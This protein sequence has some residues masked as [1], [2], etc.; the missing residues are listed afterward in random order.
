MS[1]IIKNVNKLKKTPFALSRRS[2]IDSFR[3]LETLRYVNEL[4]AQGENIIRLEAGQ[5]CFGAP[6]P[7][8]KYAQEMIARDPIQGYTDAIGMMDLRKRI[9]RYYGDTYNLDVSPAQIT[10]TVGSSGGFIFALLAAFDAGD[11]V[12]LIMPTYPAYRNILKSLDLIPVE[13]E[14][15]RADNYQPTVEL[16]EKHGGDLK[17]LIIN[18][19]ANP[20]GAM[21]SEDALED[22]CRWCIDQN[23]QL[24]SDEAYHGVTYEQEAQTALKFNHQAIV[25]NTFSKYFAMTGWRLGWLI[26]PENIAGRVKKLAEN[27]MVSPPTI[28]QH[29]A[30]KIFDHTDLLDD[31]VFHYRKNRDIL[32]K[33]L[34]AAGIKTLS[35]AQGAFYFY[36][37]I[38]NLTD[39][40]E[41]F[42]RQMIAEAKVSATSGCDFDLTR[43]HTTMRLSYAGTPEDMTEA[44]TRLKNWLA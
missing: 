17:G 21:I 11:K 42:C 1:L 37:D 6:E 14:A 15:S 34:P 23:V 40:S 44:C 36:A 13:I 9:A 35:S 16:L 5:P 7:A 8:L 41:D 31:Y 2:D 12:G 38:A 3:A 20:T 24:V 18:S 25:T 4:I 43:G 27:L 10:V 29:L 39:D 26:M 19:P 32:R 28:S 33:H 22:I 30:Y